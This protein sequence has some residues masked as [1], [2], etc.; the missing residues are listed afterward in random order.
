M[1][2]P[3]YQSTTA[4]H[5]RGRPSLANEQRIRVRKANNVTAQP[6]RE[7]LLSVKSADA[8]GGR[9]WFRGRAG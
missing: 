7:A 2:S 1:S 8:A 4:T 3:P 6:E 5:S 9:N